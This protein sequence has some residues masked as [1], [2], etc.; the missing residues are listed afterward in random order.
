MGAHELAISLRTRNDQYIW[1]YTVPHL[2]PR[3]THSPGYCFVRHFAHIKVASPQMY[4][5]IIY[6]AILLIVKLCKCVVFCNFFSPL[7]LIFLRFSHVVVCGWIQSFF[8][9]VYFPLCVS[10]TFY[11]FI[12][13]KEMSIW[14]T[15]SLGL[16]QIVL[17]LGVSLLHLNSKSTLL[18]TFLLL[19][20]S[21]EGSRGT[22]QKERASPPGSWCFPPSCFSVM[23]ASEACDSQGLSPSSKFCWHPGDV[24][25]LT[26]LG[27]RPEVAQETPGTPWPW[28]LNP[29]HVCSFMELSLSPWVLCIA[30]LSL[31]M[32]KSLVTR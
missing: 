11:L 18:Y 32:S 31:L 22:L 26:S 3:G 8:T 1:N 13:L 5:Y 7:N 25:L 20:L 24:V 19:D 17:Q 9:T 23:A 16:W 27:C 2:T 28:G 6:C 21:L 15:S 4:S 30:C 29:S 14:V 10:T 12:L